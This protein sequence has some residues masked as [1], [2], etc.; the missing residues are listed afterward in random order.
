M[1]FAIAHPTLY[2][3]LALRAEYVRAYR[4]FVYIRR[5][6][7]PLVPLRQTLICRSAKY[8]LSQGR[9]KAPKQ[10][11][12]EELHTAI[13][14]MRFGC[15]GAPETVKRFDLMVALGF[16]DGSEDRLHSAKQTQPHYAA[17]DQSMRL[18][19]TE[20][21][22]VVELMQT[23][24]TELF[25]GLEETTTS[26]RAGLVVPIPA[27]PSTPLSKELASDRQSRYAD[28]F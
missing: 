27:S 3:R 15:L 10:W 5:G 14:S 13:N 7:L 28:C 8:A 22:F 23:R 16:V 17:N 24:Q 4:F 1:P 20:R 18:T 11:D 19:T 6:I 9:L 25:P 21:S 12:R 26:S 2:H